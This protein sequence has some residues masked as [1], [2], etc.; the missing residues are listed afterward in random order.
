MPSS[1]SELLSPASSSVALAPKKP[2]GGFRAIGF[3]VG[4]PAGALCILDLEGILRP[5][6]MEVMV[7]G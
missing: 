2:G 4:G 3:R 6:P 7:G 1:W 5:K